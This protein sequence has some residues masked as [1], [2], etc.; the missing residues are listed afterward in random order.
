M[1]CEIVGFRI[2]FIPTFDISGHFTLITEFNTE[3]NSFVKVNLSRKKYYVLRICL[4]F[5]RVPLSFLPL[6]EEM[7]TNWLF[8]CVIFF[9]AMMLFCG[10]GIG[11]D[12][13]LKLLDKPIFLSWFFSYFLLLKLVK[14]TDRAPRDNAI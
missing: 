4:F 8:F 2:I 11:K 13:T 1:G 14:K 5:H 9:C 10:C 12:V 6:C 7:K 3:T